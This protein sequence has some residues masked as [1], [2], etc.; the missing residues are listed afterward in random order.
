MWS[1]PTHMSCNVNGLLMVYGLVCAVPVP[2]VV[3]CVCVYDL[4]IRN[5]IR[6]LQPVGVGEIC[7]LRSTYKCNLHS[8][9]MAW[10]HS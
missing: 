10:Q 8:D 6:R 2:I 1:A 5:C 7:M 9:L 4:T 3:L